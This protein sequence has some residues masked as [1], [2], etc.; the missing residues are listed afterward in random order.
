MDQWT[1]NIFQKMIQI[2]KEQAK[3][4]SDDETNESKENKKDVPDQIDM[5]TL[6]KLNC[7]VA[8][9]NFD[10]DTP[11]VILGMYLMVSLNY[12]TEVYE[13]VCKMAITNKLRDNTMLVF[14][15]RHKAELSMIIYGMLMTDFK[16]PETLLKAAK[17]AS[18]FFRHSMQSGILYCEFIKSIKN[19]DFTS[20][21]TKQSRYAKQYMQILPFVTFK[22]LDDLCREAIDYFSKRLEAENGKLTESG[23][24]A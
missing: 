1:D 19:L 21:P 15:D 18:R 22:D 17:V 4:K 11:Q 20:L 10:L 6:F 9:V 13:K 3:I 2:A 23:N 16:S 7:P 14:N 12:D 5:N 8:K 24:D